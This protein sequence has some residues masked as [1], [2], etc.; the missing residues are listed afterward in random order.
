MYGHRCLKRQTLQT[1]EALRAGSRLRWKV[2]QMDERVSRRATR[3]DQLSA[4]QR[5]KIT[6]GTAVLDCDGRSAAAKRYRDIATNLIEDQG[7]RCTEARL[8]LIRRFAGCSVLAESLEAKLASGEMIDV[9]EYTALASALVRISTRIGI[10]HVAAPVP[11]MVDFLRQ[12][13]H[14][15]DGSSRNN[16][17]DGN[18]ATVDEEDVIPSYAGIDER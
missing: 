14:Q 17:D 9:A 15:L 2:N 3:V 18:D 10:N 1:Q 13:G 11:S 7:D 4:R 5:S 16:S 6:N 8:Q 12:R